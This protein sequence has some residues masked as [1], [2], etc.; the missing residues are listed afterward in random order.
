ML[1]QVRIATV[2]RVAAALVAVT[3]S[4]A[5]RVFALASPPAKHRCACQAHAGARHE[6]ECALCHQA[7]LAA[8]ASDESLPPCHRAAAQQALAGTG[9]R[10]SRGAPC[11]EGTCGTGAKPPVTAAGVEPFCLPASGALAIA[12]PERPLP[13]FAGPVRERAVEPET[14]P[15]RAA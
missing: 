13:V 10:S 14:P 11:V 3:L 15:P 6:C 5:P 8:Q 7:V 9:G 1:R 4:G 12:L 2:A